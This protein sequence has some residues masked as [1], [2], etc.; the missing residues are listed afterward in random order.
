PS[1][2]P[3]RAAPRRHDVARDRT[4]AAICRAP[5]RRAGVRRNRARLRASP[6]ASWNRRT[7][8]LPHRPLRRVQPRKRAPPGQSAG[9]APRS[10]ARRA[11]YS[12][13]DKAQLGTE[14]KP[15]A[16]CGESLAI[17]DEPV[18]DVDLE[19]F[20]VGDLVSEATHLRADQPPKDEWQAQQ[21]AA[22]G[23]VDHR[24]LEAGFRMAEGAH[25]G[26]EA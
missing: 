22:M 7:V 23:L 21:E 24:S 13:D 10:R 9:R 17:E 16:A 18:G 20:G 11:W 2:P 1:W 5:P 25:S 26:R 6:F 19:I 15:V 8:P 4:R 14:R 12:R 3:W